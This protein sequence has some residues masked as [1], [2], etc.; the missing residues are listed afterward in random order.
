[1][2]DP[3][4]SLFSPRIG[5]KP[6]AALARRLA[7]SLEA[8]IDVRKI[9]DREARGGSWIDRPRFEIVSQGVNVGDTLSESLARTGAFFPLLFREMVDVGE[10]TGSL[11]EVFRRLADHY[12]HR[13]KTR[14]VFLQSITGPMLQL[15]AALTVI[16]LLIWIMGFLAQRR[17][18]EPVDLL[19]FGLIGAPGLIVYLAILGTIF[20]GAVFVLFAIRRGL[21]WTRPI[22]HAALRI[23]VVGG[24]LRTMA[25]AQMAWTL[26]LTMNVAMDLRQLLPI[27]LRSTGNDYYARRSEEVVADV[28]GG[29]EIHE[30]LRATRAFPEEFLE[31]LEVG[32]LSGS[33]VES[34]GRLSAQYEE[35]ARA[36]VATLATL[37]GFAVW[38]AVAML[39]ILLIFRLASFY[40][41]AINDALAM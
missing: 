16:G 11:S 36:A 22:Q 1:M 8:G 21:A 9:W 32:E 15:A 26:H 33:L 17:G 41:G 24:C 34:M 38:A 23:P 37:A 25:L 14:R 27:A 2:T 28:V 4:Q 6:L 29:R 39:I 35:R 18:G 12:E 7:I 40:L 30:A 19:G 5:P 13:L 3:L 10:K 31:V 20:G